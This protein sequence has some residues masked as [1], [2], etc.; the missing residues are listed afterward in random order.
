MQKA[1][2]EVRLMSEI[3]QNLLSFSKAGLRERNI[4]LQ[5]VPLRELV[6]DVAAIE[7]ES[8][9]LQVEIPDSLCALGDYQLLFC[10]LSNVVRNSLRYA[11]KAGTDPHRGPGVR[12][13][14]A[15]LQLAIADQGPGA[16]PESLDHLFEPFYRPESARTRETGGTGLGLAIVKS[17][18]EACGGQ[19]A[20]ENVAPQGLRITF[21]L[22]RA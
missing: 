5:P 20:V 4:Q 22:K 3:V 1:L 2:S 11:G 15:S 8:T 18:I 9:D 10:A 7:A 19:V 13:F 16:P 12:R 6:L 14:H 17:C 21:Q